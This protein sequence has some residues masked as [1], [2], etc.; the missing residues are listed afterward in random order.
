MLA[1]NISLYNKS[2]IIQ[3]CSE[4]WLGLICWAESSLLLSL[5]V[6]PLSVWQR[7]VLVWTP[8][9]SLGLRVGLQDCGLITATK[10]GEKTNSRLQE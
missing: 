6:Q 10:F 3:L 1:C 4:V 8:G 2:H 9:G 5:L 7:D